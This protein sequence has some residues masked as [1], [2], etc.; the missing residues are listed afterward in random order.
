M[1]RVAGPWGPLVQ[2]G[3]TRG[4]HPS[5]P[6]PPRGPTVTF[7]P[8]DAKGPTVLARWEDIEEIKNKVK[9]EKNF[10]PCEV[11]SWFPSAP[12]SFALICWS[13]SSRSLLSKCE[14]KRRT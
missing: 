4:C 14:D 9:Q 13:T 10:V 1:A 8:A 5:A 6:P 7:M 3:V 11:G 2:C 12:D